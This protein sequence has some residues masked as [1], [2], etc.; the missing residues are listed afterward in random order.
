MVTG[1]L[2]VSTVL[3][4]PLGA[5]VGDWLGWRATLW[6]VAAF[7]LVA[8]AGAARVPAQPLGGAKAKA[9]FAVLARPGMLPVLGVTVGQLAAIFTIYTYLPAASSPGVTE[10]SSPC[11]FCST[12]SRGWPATRWPAGSRTG[13]GRWRC[14]GSGC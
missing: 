14:C 10:A 7:G 13:S 1:G 4:A 8:C 11:C 3:G 6:L 2:T 12:A 9:R 5:L